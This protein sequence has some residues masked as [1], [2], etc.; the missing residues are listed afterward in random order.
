MKTR[1]SSVCILL[2]VVLLVGCRATKD[3]T[4]N[5]P[6]IPMQAE[7]YEG[8]RCPYPEDYEVLYHMAGAL[9]MADMEAVEAGTMP[10]G[11]I[12]YRF[13]DP[14]AY[15]SAAGKPLSALSQEEQLALCE[16]LVAEN[17]GSTDGFTCEVR[18]YPNGVFAFEF[19][20]A[21]QN[22]YLYFA[23]V[24]QTETELLILAGAGTEQ[25][26][27]VFEATV[28]A[29]LAQ[30]D[31]VVEQTASVRPEWRPAVFTT[32]LLSEA[33]AMAEYRAS[34]G[35]V[36]TTELFQMAFEVLSDAGQTVYDTFLASVQ[37]GTPNSAVTLLQASDGTLSVQDGAE[38]WTQT[39]EI[40]ANA[41]AAVNKFSFPDTLVFLRYDGEGALDYF[42]LV[43]LQGSA[44]GG[45]T[46]F[47]VVHTEDDS[48]ADAMQVSLGNGW[49]CTETA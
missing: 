18:Q 47:S 5:L 11:M 27:T 21:E 37:T 9:L 40:E 46:E 45:I 16:Q 6:D 35:M 24:Y 43:F 48:I 41:L 14:K 38:H 20:H 25:D 15:Q 31:P 17:A 26:K 29:F 4:E 39:E 28:A 7:V 19:Y 30:D 36:L 44:S 32:D 42:E 22:A 12:E 33:D 1:R 34:K 2:S 23:P 3:W 8:I 10:F 49:Y 13:I